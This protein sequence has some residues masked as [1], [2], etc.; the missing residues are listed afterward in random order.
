MKRY[1]LTAWLLPVF[2]VLSCTHNKGSVVVSHKLKFGRIAAKETQFKNIDSCKAAAKAY[3]AGHSGVLVDTVSKNPL[4]LSIKESLPKGEK[5]EVRFSV[6]PNT[7]LDKKMICYYEIKGKSDKD[8]SANKDSID[9]AIAEV[10]KKNKNV[11]VL[12]GPKLDTISVNQK[13]AW[14]V[15]LH[16]DQEISDNK[17]IA[18][19]GD[20]GMI[21]NPPYPP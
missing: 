20:F 17:L 10:R 15:L 14:R 2:V 18:V 8:N 12:Q 3:V 11:I 6:N 21:T 19:N 1:L 4:I 7:T 13:Q 5:Y 9:V 16:T